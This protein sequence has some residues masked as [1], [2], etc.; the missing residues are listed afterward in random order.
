MP[1]SLC[2]QNVYKSTCPTVLTSCFWRQRA[3]PAG[4]LRCLSGQLTMG[5]PVST[6]GGWSSFPRARRSIGRKHRPCGG[7]NVS[8]SLLSARGFGPRAR[9]WG[10]LVHEGSNFSS[11]PRHLR[12]SNP[13]CD[14]AGAVS[15]FPVLHS[16]VCLLWVSVSRRWSW[17]LGW[18]AHDHTR[19]A[20]LA[21]HSPGAGPSSSSPTATEGTWPS[22]PGRLP[23]KQNPTLCTS[24]YVIFS[25]GIGG[26]CPI[27]GRLCEKTD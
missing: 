25:S 17:V 1:Q 18:K 24:L 2:G 9:V 6:P 26:P 20:C 15:F 22:S 11:T 12:I 23:F 3:G 13:L 16:D 14:A 27:S 21:E 7:C 10:G 5:H 19:Q 8:S 4:S